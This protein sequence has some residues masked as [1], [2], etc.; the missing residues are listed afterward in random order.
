MNDKTRSFSV[1]AW[2]V[3]DGSIVHYDDV[4]TLTYDVETGVR[5]IKFIKS[6]EIR[7]LKDICIHKINDIDVYL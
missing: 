6:R 2:K 3:K 1:T 5:R 4:V 7:T